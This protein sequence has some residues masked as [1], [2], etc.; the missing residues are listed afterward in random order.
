[1]DQDTADIALDLVR[2]TF[3]VDPEH[4]DVIEAHL[5]SLGADVFT[6]DEGRFLVTWEEPEHALDEVVEAIWGLNEAPFE[7]I[8]EEF[9]RISLNLLQ[10]QEDEDEADE[11]TEEGEA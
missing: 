8:Q 11:A 7:V 5:D 1:M 6:G 9:H 3:T 2:W 10:F 4:A